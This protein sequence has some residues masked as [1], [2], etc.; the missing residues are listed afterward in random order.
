[1][2]GSAE[3]AESSFPS[4]LDLRRALQLN[5]ILQFFA[6]LRPPSAVAGPR[7]ARSGPGLGER[8]FRRAER[9]EP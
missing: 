1:M 9:E 3:A 7:R 6:I 8:P 4:V 2:G 5:L